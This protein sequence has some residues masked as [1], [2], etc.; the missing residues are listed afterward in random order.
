MMIN[1][2]KEDIQDINTIIKQYKTVSSKLSNYKKE[3]EEIQ[4]NVNI[5]NNE[6]KNIMNKEQILMTELHKKY[7]EFCLQDVYNILNHDNKF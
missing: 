5:L 6:L 1:F 2:S 3:M 4:E 7:G